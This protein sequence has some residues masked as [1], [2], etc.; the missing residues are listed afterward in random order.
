MTA[1]V[2]PVNAPNYLG[3]TLDKVPENKPVGS[4]SKSE[5]EITDMSTSYQAAQA[6]QSGI[7]NRGPLGQ[8]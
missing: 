6:K 2:L 5:K 8:K 7:G 4:N 1:L 3:L